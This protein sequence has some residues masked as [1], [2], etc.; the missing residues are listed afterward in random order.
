MSRVLLVSLIAGLAL[1]APARA[2]A[3]P[4]TVLDFE[5]PAL[6]SEPEGLYP[7]SGVQLSAPCSDIG[8]AALMRQSCGAVVAPGHDSRQS[9]NVSGFELVARFDRKQASVSMWISATG[10]EGN[11]RLT[12]TGWPGEPF[13]GGPV[14][15]VTL[16]HTAEAWGGGEAAVLGSDVGEPSIA[17]V[18]VTIDGGPQ[19]WVDDLAFSESPQ[20]D[21]II[22]SGPPDPT[23]AADAHFTFDANQPAVSFAC[24]LD[25]QGAVPCRSS[26]DYTGIA[27][28]THTFKVAATDRYQFADRTPAEYTWRIARPLRAPAPAPPDADGDG[29]PDARDNCPATANTSQADTDGDAIGDACETVP[30]GN[31]AP[32]TG[33]S[34]V[35]Q[36]LSGDVFVKLPGGAR[37]AVARAA[38]AA[39]IAGF[40]P[41]K[42]V[43]SL[44]TGT[45]VDARKGRLLLQSTVDGRRIGQGGQR[46]TATL[47][48]GI[49]RIRQERLRAGSTTRI[50]TDFVLTSAPG[51]ERACVRSSISGPAK[52]R[53]RSVVRSLSATTTKGL[54]RIVGA[55]GTSTGRN[56]T[57]VTQDRCDGTR[58]DVGR[59]R[60]AVFDEPLDRTVT[61][62]AGRSYI[63]KARLFAARKERRR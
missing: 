51:A 46:Q 25:N 29:V 9:L 20:P 26:I 38:Q 58:T 23:A 50:P 44:P 15:T 42:G 48:A 55:A 33:E 36:V 56:S 57:W 13:S 7:G 14:D 60:V 31:V 32:V 1:A 30:E 8:A 11:P 59:G 22:T 41:L 21:T 49:F 18:T 28:G 37:G 40:V 52:G 10:F 5:T 54:F 6:G 43:A 63:A 62:T 45:V 27:E 34:V 61:V 39:P 4:P 12:V 2:A 35:V 19:F 17:S 16:E 47:A 3:P 24:S 53:G